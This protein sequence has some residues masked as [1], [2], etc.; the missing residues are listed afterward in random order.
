MRQIKFRAWDGNSMITPS[1]IING[2][3]AII[4]VCDINDKVMTDNEGSH[5]YKN[6]DMDVTTDYPLMQFTGAFDLH[7]NEL[8]EDDICYV[9]G[10]GNCRV[11]IRHFYG[12]TFYAIDG[13]ECPLI[14][15]MA[16]N[17]SF[18]RIGNIHENPG[19]LEK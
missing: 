3:A 13:Q 1:A 12:V 11:G 6:W 19:L 15:C 7:S 17:D 4:K 16:E 14:D 18:K 9:E 5:Y 10:L 8:Y 2:K